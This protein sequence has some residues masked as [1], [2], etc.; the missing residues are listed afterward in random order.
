MSTTATVEADRILK[1]Y[2]GDDLPDVVDADR[3]ALQRARSMKLRADARARRLAEAQARKD[4]ED[5]MARG[6]ATPPGVS[7]A[8]H[9]PDQKPSHR[10]QRV[11]IVQ[12]N[13][14]HI[15][16]SSRPFVPKGQ[17]HNHGHD[18]QITDKGGVS[19]AKLNGGPSKK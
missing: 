2:G 15:P 18:R 7:L 8:P 10:H 13:D 4:K 3:D 16:S 11:T 6:E 1:K 12:S 19:F 5:R 17:E 9:P 14:A